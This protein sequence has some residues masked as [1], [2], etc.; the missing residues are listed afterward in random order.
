MF[1]TTFTDICPLNSAWK[2]PKIT[3]SVIFAL[4]KSRFC[5]ELWAILDLNFGHFTRFWPPKMPQKCPKMPTKCP[6]MSQNMCKNHQWSFFKKSIFGDF[7]TF[8]THFRSFS[9]GTWKKKKVPRCRKS[10]FRPYH[11]FS[12]EKSWLLSGRTAMIGAILKIFFFF[13]WLV[14]SGPIS[15]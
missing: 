10:H 3:F 12:L 2:T 13:F 6:K 1:G 4:R 8:M 14:G 9:A 15:S 5:I 11:Y 7:S